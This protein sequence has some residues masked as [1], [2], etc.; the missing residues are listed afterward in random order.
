MACRPALAVFPQR[1]A[2]IDETPKVIPRMDQSDEEESPNEDFRSDKYVPNELPFRVAN[3]S[4]EKKVKE[5]E[6]VKRKMKD[7]EEDE[8]MIETGLKRQVS[9]GAEAELSDDD[10]PD[11]ELQDLILKENKETKAM[12][13]TVG[14]EEPFLVQFPGTLPLT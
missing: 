4:D 12:D 3:M 11:T 7:N 6:E 5:L 10:H 9:K 2:K 1:N 8:N 14:E 13:L